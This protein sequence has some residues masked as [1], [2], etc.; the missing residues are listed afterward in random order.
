MR[1][2]YSTQVNEVKKRSSPLAGHGAIR[3]IS[4]C[5]V[6]VCTQLMEVFS[7]VESVD[8]VIYAIF[9]RLN[10]DWK[11]PPSNFLHKALDVALKQTSP[12]AEE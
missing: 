7:N 11:I 6:E 8:R 12:F 2:L 4:G 5:F 1:R 10:Q 9:N 3:L